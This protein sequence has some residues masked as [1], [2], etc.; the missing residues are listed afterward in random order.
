MKLDRYFLLG[1]LLVV[2]AFFILT[3]FLNNP[4]FSEESMSAILNS[5][6]RLA[7]F[8]INEIGAT[9]GQ[10]Y[11]PEVALSW[12]IPGQATS[13]TVQ[14]KA[15]KSALWTILGATD[16][17][18]LVDTNWPSD[19]QAGL[20]QYRVT[21][22][23]ETR[24]STTKGTSIR[25]PVCETAPAPSP[26]A[27]ATSTAILWGAYVGDQPSDAADF[28]LRVNKKMNLQAVFVNLG[29]DAFPS[30]FA[31]TIAGQGKTMIIFW[32]PYDITL[33]YIIAGKLD[34]YI[35]QFAAAAKNYSG[36]II[37]APF[38]EMNGDWSPWGGTVGSNTPAKV[39]FAW[40]RIHDL[41]VGVANVKF[42]W[43][44]NNDSVPDTPGNQIEKYWPGDAYVDYVG[45]DG[46]NFADPWQSFSEVFDGA[47]AKLS[48]YNKPIY[49][50]SF[51]CAPSPAKAAW[52]T[53]AMGVQIPKHPQI[54][55]WV[56]FN[57][58]KE[59]DWRVWS[60]ENS[61]A[62][63]KAVLP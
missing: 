51:A 58:N 23:N 5:K 22:S 4:S 55:A 11:L 13:Y 53:D 46:F 40:K 61:L 38:H 14:R 32:E 6:N 2:A 43:A 48:V 7:S 60:D 47:I 41:F 15:N 49:I 30:Q 8:S 50:F 28:E 45:V 37:L 20:Y 35:N 24:S 34:A 63:F 12:T 54:A 57:Q 25:V 33:D 31:P 17:T 42:G 26:T 59:K 3:A 10:N 18:S 36:P 56:W 27:A 44:V 21:A 39:V 1:A 16:Q 52:I 19:Y 62:A 9:C 29:L